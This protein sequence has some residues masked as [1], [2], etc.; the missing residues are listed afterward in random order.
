MRLRQLD[1][2]RGI[3]V[4]L[5]L[6]RHDAL[7]EM[8]Y[9]VGWVGVDLFFVLSGFL[10]SGLLFNEFIKY[11]NIKPGLFLIRR[12]FKIYPLFYTFLVITI[13]FTVIFNQLGWMSDNLL[14][15]G[16]ISEIFFVQ[17]YFGHIWDHTWSLAVEEHFYF[18]LAFIFFIFDRK[19]I[20]A[21]RKA[22]I[23]LVSIVSLGCLTLRIINFELYHFDINTHLYR[24]HL[25]IDSLMFGVFLSYMYHFEKERFTDFFNKYKYILLLTGL[26]LVSSCAIFEINTFFMNTFGLT[27]LYLGF[28]SILGVMMSVKDVNKS[29]DKFMGKFTVDVISKIGFFSYSI[30]LWHM[31]VIKYFLGALEKLSPVPISNWI[32][33][34]FYLLTSIFFAMGMSKL[35]ELKFLKIRDQRF[36]SRARKI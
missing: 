28:G 21:N 17:N 23:V 12:G 7:T 1:F 13:I 26:I 2:L 33:F 22:F 24:T 15:G 10:V 8:L 14:R 25:R 20:L 36:P 31:F 29:L 6:F 27:C 5:V 3:A 35:V 11:G 16:L 18:T 19:K 30:Y 9:K 32:T 34:P 4:L